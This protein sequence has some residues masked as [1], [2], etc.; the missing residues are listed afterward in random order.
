MIFGCRDTAI[1]V[2]WPEAIVQHLAASAGPQ[3]SDKWL[4]INESLGLEAK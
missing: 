2:E 1:R 3:H 4:P